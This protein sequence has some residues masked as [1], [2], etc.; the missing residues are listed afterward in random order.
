MA[1][2]RLPY[3][4]PSMSER[5]SFVHLRVHSE[6]SVSEGAA[7]LSDGGVITRAA[8]LGMPALGL[9][10]LGNLF[11]AVKF[12]ESCRRHGVKPV[13]G[14]EIR[15]NAG[16]AHHLLLFCADN[17]GYRTLNGLLTRAYADNNGVVEAPWLEENNRGLI[18]LS[19]GERGGIA[20]ALRQGSLPQA[21][22]IAG[23]WKE[24]LGDRF[25]V[26]VWR[27]TADD[28]PAAAASAVA[29]QAG[30][31][32]VATHP[33]QCAREQ[34]R[35]ML[36]VRRCIAHNW[37]LGNGAYCQPF[38]QAPHLL[39]VEEI[40]ARFADM[41]A[42]LANTAEIAQ[43]CNFTY[44]FGRYHLPQIDLQE[45][46]SAAQALARLASAGLQQRGLPS[47]RAR[48]YQQRLLYEIEMINR[49]GF[50][51]YYLIVADFV[52]WAKRQGIPV[53]PGRGSGAGSLVAFAL[54]ITEIDP[55][56]Y[57]LLF[58]RF[59]NPERVS[60]PDFD[61]DFCVD[62]RDRVIDY[63]IEKYGHE[64]VAQIVTFGQIGA[65]SSVRDVGRVLGYPYSLCD[66]VAR[67][68]P[69]V[70]NMTLQ[71]ALEESPLLRAETKT[72]RE[73]GELLELS[74]KVEGLPR[75]IGTHAGGVLIA[76]KPIVEFC[77]LYA[78]A[79]TNSMV[80]Q[81]DMVDIEKIGLVKF[82]LLGL[83]TLTILASAEAWLCE[84]GTA[85]KNFSLQQVPLDDAKV[86]E[87][88]AHGDT[89]GVFQCESSGMRKLMKELKPDRFAD[90]I[91]LI[92]LY[93]PG[94]MK[95]T[96][97]FI[98]R[99]HGREA[100]TYPHPL[101]RKVLEET[102]GI[103]VYQEQVMEIARQ[104]AGYSL[105]EADVLRRAISK[106]KGDEIHS[107]RRR[108]VKGSE[109]KLSA[110][111][112][113]EMF[114]TIASFAGYGF[115]K[116]HAA[117]YALISY[118]TAYL[119]AY[120]P[121]A[122]YAAVMSA[123][124]GDSERL[125]ILAYCARGAGIRLLPPDINTG[126][127]DFYPAAADAICYGLQAIKGAGKA[128]VEQIVAVRGDRPFANLFDFCRR[129]GSSRLLTQ[130]AVENLIF[131]GAFDR[132]HNNR[133]A[134]RETLPLALEEAVRGDGLFGEASKAL[135][136]RVPWDERENLVNE[137]KSLGLTLSGSFY[138]LYRDFLREA[139]LRPAGLDK[140]Y[141]SGGMFRIAG[142]LGRISTPRSQR[143]RGLEV[144]VLEDDTTAEFEIAVNAEKFKALGKLQ[145]GQD[146]LI[147]EGAVGRGQFRVQGERLYTMESFV[148]ARARRL[149]VYC[150]EKTQADNLCATLAPAQ[151]RSGHCEVVLKYADARLSCLVSLGTGWR[152]G[153]LLCARLRDSTAGVKEIKVEYAAV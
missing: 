84:S 62:G 2:R 115:N 6:Y 45:G 48:E 7:R 136:D 138:S 18:V 88:Y 146:L 93:R 80:S 40:Q 47:A 139:G 122:L 8:E 140:V 91:A 69:G 22:K 147:I 76:P 129:L 137:Q 126:R 89:M 130:T 97:M 12:Y 90:I 111:K 127:R 46:E 66:R 77:P 153:I 10:D 56:P 94:P 113:G 81:M 152:P 57:G 149:S 82:D 142:V 61:I 134:A 58:E 54:D 29:A 20:R 109:S 86:Y 107:Q 143:Q 49:T 53:G 132:L 52:G 128:L 131:G 15:I 151:D 92:A 13:I 30:L 51:D 50:A 31:P 123:D 28:S 95:F 99:K 14:C 59:L 23:R 79:D 55:I 105:G 36:E 5:H 35:Q 21:L 32:V 124:A 83:K 144:L 125:K 96:D 37:L 72:D 73:V 65:R 148:Q 43:R 102:Y 108:F 121:A 71:K 1:R 19:G 114:D 145:E 98:A 17:Q 103:C 42:A 85:D 141:E 116:S 118:R 24:C 101:L 104:V 67:L 64:R 87:I 135:A 39:T 100:I 70:P 38:A 4:S 26:E 106:K 68:I 119:K 44:Q 112:A 60:M 74:R 16:P 27:A 133:A 3:N 41:P 110:D 34:D 33:V 150:D 120:Y 75:N 63:V 78:A 11:G 9:A 117:A 25:Y